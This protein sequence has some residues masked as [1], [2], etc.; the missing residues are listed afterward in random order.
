MTAQQLKRLGLGI[1]VVAA[2]WDM[3]ER[4]GVSKLFGIGLASAPLLLDNPAVRSKLAQ[5]LP[6]G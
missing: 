4:P 6:Q 5:L 2:I 1:V 3:V